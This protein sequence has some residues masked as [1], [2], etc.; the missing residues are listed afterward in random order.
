M[1]PA[2]TVALLAA[3]ICAQV[4]TVATAGPLDRLATLHVC[5]ATGDDANEG[6][7]DRAP[8]RTLHAARDAARRFRADASQQLAESPVEIILHGARVHHLTAPLVLDARD[9]HT[10]YRAADGDRVLVS[11]GVAIDP[12]AVSPRP[13]HA[14]Q[15]EV[16]MTA[17]GLTDLGTVLPTSS[18]AAKM[19]H[20]QL[21]QLLHPQLFIGEH[22]GLCTCVSANT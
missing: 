14:G 3:T 19:D 7:S 2:T 15:Y 13:G 10:V 17:M 9:S 6:T 20:A 4:I 12:T 8:L 16:N 5:A 1:A 18:G 22:A 11:G 21:D